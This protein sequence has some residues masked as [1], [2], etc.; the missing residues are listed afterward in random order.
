MAGGLESILVGENVRSSQSRDLPER[1]GPTMVSGWT[2]AH[3][4]R[5]PVR[6]GAR[7]P[8]DGPEGGFSVFLRCNLCLFSLFR[9]VTRFSAR[10]HHRRTRMNTERNA[11]SVKHPLFIGL[12]MN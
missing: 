7:R 11:A 1:R 5:N 4:A 6:M 10:H 9:E 2:W 8:G 12:R 3:S